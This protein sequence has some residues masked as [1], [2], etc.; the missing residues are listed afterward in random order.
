MTEDQ[1]NAE[2]P[3]EEEKASS[4]GKDPA[5]NS[6]SE[7]KSPEDAPT[8]EE[9]APYIPNER[10]YKKLKEAV[11][12]FKANYSRTDLE[13]IRDNEQLDA[14]CR[15]L[16]GYLI[17]NFD[18]ITSMTIYGKPGL[19]HI[20]DVLVAAAATKP[21]KKKGIS[22]FDIEA[23]GFFGVMLPAITLGIEAV[24]HMCGG[25]YVDPIPSWWHIG[26]ITFVAVANFIVWLKAMKKDVTAPWLP[27][28]LGT[29]IGVSIFYALIFL[30]LVPVSLMLLAL[31]GF[32]LLPLSPLFA[33]L[34]AV[35]LAFIVKRMR[36]EGA[37][38][39]K[40]TGVFRGIVTG[41]AFLVLAELPNAVT[42]IA[43][44]Q[45]ASS[46]SQTSRAGVRLL[47]TFGN[48]QSLL[49]SCYHHSASVSDIPTLVLT[50]LTDNPIFRNTQ[51]EINRSNFSVEDARNIYYRAFGRPFNSVARPSFGSGYRNLGED[52]MA[53]RDWDWDRDVELAGEDVG[54]RTVGVSL[55]KSELS[56]AVDPNAATSY[57]EWTMVFNNRSS[58]QQE[59]R[60][61]VE[62]PPGG[63]VSRATLWVNGQ[64]REAAFGERGLVRKAYQSVVRKK[65]DPLLVTAVGPNKI[66]LQCF[67][68]P[69]QK[70]KQPGEIKVRIGITAPCLVPEIGQA[71]LTLPRIAEHGFPVKCKHEVRIES[72]QAFT[73]SAKSMHPLDDATTKRLIGSIE[74][75]SLSDAPITIQSPRDSTVS[76]LWS[77]APLSGGRS[78]VV[79][80]FKRNE[81]TKPEKLYVVI[82][83]SS[84]MAKY[85]PQIAEA[86]AKIPEDVPTEVVFAS[87]EIYKLVDS[88]SK[89]DLKVAL[90]EL[91]HAP[92]VG[93]PNN[94]T[95][96][97]Q[98][99]KKALKRPNSA[100]LW[101]HG[102]QPVLFDP[103]GALYAFEP[104]GQN[105][106]HFPVLYDVEAYP[107]PNR[108]LEKMPP[109]VTVQEVPRP[110]DIKSDLERFI[111]GL[112]GTGPANYVIA[113][114]TTTEKPQFKETIPLISAQLVSLWAYDET[115]D[116]LHKGQ[117]PAAVKLAAHHR[118]VTPVTGAV[119]LETDEDYK[120]NG[121]DP[122]NPDK[123]VDNSSATP[124][125]NM[126]AAPEPEENAL[127]L[128]ALMV[129]A[130]QIW[131][132][133][134]YARKLA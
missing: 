28:M 119:V 41:A 63:V 43:L 42:D 108:L 81:T 50:Y 92:C 4:A 126:G 78:F 67:P 46:N 62:L 14:G 73:C 112:C 2:N 91:K 47:R 11:P 79:E 85:M 117:N 116:M 94:E 33:F 31:I 75:A 54:G 36:K 107:S 93:G 76:A 101:I 16:A 55:A 44:R 56:T 6:P 88:K 121:I 51:W 70:D 115:L 72:P 106:Q 97:G 82:D 32:G 89:V 17:D 120:K 95:P 35:R 134:S 110:S 25:V 100:V 13:G 114:N 53:F 128:L 12:L 130:W 86:L 118:L 77:A 131:R 38:P 68:V 7:S 84:A 9:Q 98:V 133:K 10:D 22:W 96:L 39:L 129:M 3:P 109:N 21:E 30:P 45:A 69:P 34:S 29:S 19:V 20:K 64:P 74:D 105:L 113:R 60:M 52:D 48:E 90:Q 49:R 103:Y 8:K 18:T 83:G 87:D 61:Q 23:I 5:S 104:H 24:F 102:P 71:Q 27:F 59:A 15:K 80:E 37:T 26:A 99:W 123:N 66:M 1:N 124:G 65:R 111:S 58:D 122:T 125:F 132:K 127:M 40:M 57:S